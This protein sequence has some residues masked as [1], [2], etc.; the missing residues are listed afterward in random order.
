MCEYMAPLKPRSPLKAGVLSL[1]APGLGQ[2]Y[3]GQW[4]KA[5]FFFIAEY[6]LGVW[7]TTR[8]GSF[9]GMIQGLSLLLLF[10]AVTVGDAAI[11]AGRQQQY[12]PRSFNKGWIYTSVLVLS[13][14]GTVGLDWFLG[15]NFY[16]TFKVPSPSMV[17]SLVPGDRFMGA[18]LDPLERLQRG[19]V[20]VFHPPGRERI[21]YVKRVVGL[22]GELVRV[23]C[24]HVRINGQ[25]LNEGHA[26]FDAGGSVVGLPS[27]IER[28]L[29]IDEY[30]LMGDNRNHSRDSRVFGPVGRKRIGYRALYLYWA[31][32]GAGAV[33]AGDRLGMR[34]D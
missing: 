23:D 33:S 19:D 13:L 10:M 16:Q 15:N 27:R 20:V 25:L 1:L 11:S 17:P 32:E 8:F 34:L 21:W 29:G 18:A 5:L 6:P 3:N 12:V 9:A 26:R 7:A 28:L 24:G 4:G 2:L 22:P 14:L 30:W 31:G